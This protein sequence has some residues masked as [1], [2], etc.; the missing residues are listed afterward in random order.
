ME[1]ICLKCLIREVSFIHLTVRMKSER[2]ALRRAGEERAAA[3]AALV[4]KEV[5]G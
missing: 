2:R 4:R 1:C 3:L 5:Y